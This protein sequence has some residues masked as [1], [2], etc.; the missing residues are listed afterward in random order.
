MH[1]SRKSSVSAAFDELSLM[2]PLIDVLRAEGMVHS[3]E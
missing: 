1:I 3:V 2:K